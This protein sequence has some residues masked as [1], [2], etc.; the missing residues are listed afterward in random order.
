M[1]VGEVK[2][3]KKCESQRLNTI[4][5]AHLE[6]NK[7]LQRLAN[8]LKRESVTGN[9]QTARIET[10]QRPERRGEMKCDDSN[11]KMMLE[12]KNEGVICISAWI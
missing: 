8:P 2:F 1:R 10:R 6:I 3:Y 11:D 4:H 9:L 5:T 7:E 12:R